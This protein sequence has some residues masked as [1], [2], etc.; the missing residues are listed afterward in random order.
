MKE[1]INLYKYSAINEWTLKS[2]ENRSVHFTCPNNFNDPFDCR[3]NIYMNGSDEEWKAHLN[4]IGKIDVDLNTFKE[5]EILYL[6]NSDTFQLEL[7]NLALDTTRMSCFTTEPNNMLLW[8]HYANC[9][10]GICLVYQARRY[11]TFLYMEF[12]EADVTY[13]NNQLASNCGGI[14]RVNYSDT[15]PPAYN[16][17]KY[18]RDELAPFLLTKS[19]DWSYEKEWRMI[20]PSSALANDDPR[21]MDGY[22][23]GVIF[24]LR[25]TQQDIVRVKAA[26]P[27]ARYFQSVA[28]KREY[29]VDIVELL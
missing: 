4:R 2:L 12:D 7:Q 25:C 6:E 10:R 24:G 5:Q 27:N 17:L 26:T 1:T 3:L 8:S 15:L 21:L 16:H 11:D 14:M 18:N 28:K 22:F 13:P 23:M 19:E 29:M 20:L 9:H